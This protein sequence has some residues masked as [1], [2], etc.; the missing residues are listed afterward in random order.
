MLDAFRLKDELL[1]VTALCLSGWTTRKCAGGNVACVH[2]YLPIYDKKEINILRVPLSVKFSITI[3]TV[4]VCVCTMKHVLYAWHLIYAETDAIY[5]ICVY[6]CTLGKVVT[7]VSAGAKSTRTNRK[8][9]R[10][11]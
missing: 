5:N 1:L 8:S 10:Y 11:F 7:N 9:A 4:C 3:C 6:V 2:F